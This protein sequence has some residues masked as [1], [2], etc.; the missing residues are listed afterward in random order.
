MPICG[1]VFAAQSDDRLKTPGEHCGHEKNLGVKTGGPKMRK[2]ES[3]YRHG[4]FHFPLPPASVIMVVS[5]LRSI[6][7]CDRI[8]A[9]AG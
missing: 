4:L 1:Q 7:G 2:R 5:P 3:D 8:A 9:C 6:A